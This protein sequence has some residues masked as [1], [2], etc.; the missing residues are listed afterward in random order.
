MSKIFFL[1]LVNTSNII[2]TPLSLSKWKKKKKL[3]KE[4]NKNM[5]MIQTRAVWVSQRGGLT[6]GDLIH[7][8]N[9]KLPD[10]SARF[11]PTRE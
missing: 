9:P 11:A 5:V 10:P 8:E 6:N 1:N 4:K 3:N 2:L 7:A